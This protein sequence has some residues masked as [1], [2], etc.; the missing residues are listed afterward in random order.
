[1]HSYEKL[2]LRTTDL[3]GTS[4]SYPILHAANPG[5]LA[6]ASFSSR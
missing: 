1:M 6:I 3:Y 2:T 5:V 4:E